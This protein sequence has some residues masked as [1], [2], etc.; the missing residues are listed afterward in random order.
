MNQPDPLEVLRTE[1]ALDKKMNGRQLLWLAVMTVVIPVAVL[2][3]VA[4]VL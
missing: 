3:G 4:V 1:D 2:I